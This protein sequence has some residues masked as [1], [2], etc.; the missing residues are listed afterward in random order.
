MARTRYQQRDPELRFRELPFAALRAV[1]RE[2]YT[3]QD[4]RRDVLAG[5][6]VGIVTL[7]LAMALG[8][9]VGVSPQYALYTAIVAGFVAALLGGSRLQVTGPTAAFIV[10]LAPICVQFG[11]GGLLV[12]GLIGGG[13][14]VVMA[15]MRLGRLV[16]FIPH[17]VTTGFTA[18]IAT[19][20]AILQLQD[21][22]GIRVGSSDPHLVQV[23]GI[24]QLRCSPPSSST[25]W[26]RRGTT[27][28]RSSW[29][30]ELPT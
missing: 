10:V 29:P 27:Q 13:I 11:L 3:L 4:A 17:P 12:S 8:V 9:G 6:V 26:R 18:G 14:L 28:T 16:Q 5:L 22:L 25:G 21:L 19:V 30:R 20:I 1:L 7:P 2:G 23:A 15:I 24:P